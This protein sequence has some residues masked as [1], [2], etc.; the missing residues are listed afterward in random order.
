MN[1]IF[2][3]HNI[4]DIIN[5]TKT[6]LKIDP[7]VA[8]FNIDYKIVNNK[9]ILEG[10]VTDQY[11]ID[12]LISNCKELDI[13]ENKIELLPSLKLGEKVFGLVT[14]SVCNI[15]IKPEHSSELSTQALCGTP[16]KVLKESNGFYLIQTPDDYIGW[17]EPDGIVRMSKEEIQKWLSEKKVIYTSLFGV[18]YSNEDKKSDII[19]DCVLGNVF[20]YLSKGEGYYKIELPDKRKGFIPINECKDY[21]DWISNTECNAKNIIMTAKKMIGFPYL[22]GGTSVKGLDC[23]GFTKTVFFMQG[24]ILPRDASQQVLIGEDISLENNFQSLKPGDLL[25]FGKKTD[26]G[27]EKITHVA[28]YIGNLEYIH[29]TGL[30][31]INSLD[32]QKSNFNLK[33]FETLLKAKRLLG[34]KEINNFKLINNKFYNP[35]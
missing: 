35:K 24:V 8:V 19:S 21:S 12:K 5:A 15:R 6:E 4:Q 7:R 10:E 30:V 11:Y 17:T 25:F 32:K 27:K 18:I 16:A 13:L 2:A 14:I 1:K 3:Q 28:I 20:K 33:R 29:S 23:S 34:I 31:R 26:L 9:L 22:W